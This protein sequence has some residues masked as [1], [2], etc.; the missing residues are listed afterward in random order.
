[1]PTQA[2]KKNVDAPVELSGLK[3]IAVALLD[4]ASTDE[5]ERGFD[6][7]NAR[8]GKAHREAWLRRE[9]RR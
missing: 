5:S 3:R 9:D 6:P 1:M 7:Y 8:E 4:R 2:N